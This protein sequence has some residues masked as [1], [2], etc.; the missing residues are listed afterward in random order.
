MKIGIVLGGGAVKG[1]YQI[2][3]L[4]ALLEH[5]SMDE[6]QALSCSSIGV[7]NGYALVSNKLQQAYDIWKS[8]NFDSMSDF[9]K[10]V[11]SK[12]LLHKII[13]A[14]AKPTDNLEIPMYCSV[15]FLPLLKL[16]YYKFIGEYKKTNQL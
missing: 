14:V 13:D 7:I 5:I 11:W 16:R 2:G 12:K 9:I 4:K 8:L 15:C 6:I 3:F 10:N 1:A